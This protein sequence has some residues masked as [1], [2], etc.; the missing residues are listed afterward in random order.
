MTDETHRCKDYLFF[1]FFLISDFLCQLVMIAVSSELHTELHTLLDA[2][3]PDILVGTESWLTP[4][5]QNSEIIPP[6]LGYSMFREDR[7]SSVGG[8]VFIL[9]KDTIIASEMPQFKTDCEVLWIKLE[10]VGRK[11]LFIAAYYR[12]KEGDALST[13]EFQ[14]SIEMVSQQKGDIWILGDLNY[15]K[16]EWDEDDVPFIKPGCSH[17]K[18]YDSFIETMCDHSLSQMVREPTRSGNILDLFLTTYPTLVNSVSIIP[19]LSDHNIVKCIDDT[20]PKLTRK[21]PRKAHLYRKANWEDFRTHMQFFCDDFMYFEQLWCDFK[22]ALNGG[23][24]K[25][26]PSRLVGRKRH[27]PWIT[28]AI[29][30][31]IRK[32]DHLFQKFKRSKDPKDRSAFLKSRHSV[33]QKIKAA[34]NK[35]LE[36]IL[37]LKDQSGE[38]PSKSAFSRKKL[39]SFIKSS[40]TDTQGI[41]ILKK[42]ESNYTQSADQANVL[43]SQFQSVFSIRSPLDLYKLCHS[44]LLNGAASLTSLLPEDIQCKFPVMSDIEISVNGVAKLLS[45]LNSAKAAGPDA[46]RPIVLKELSHVIAPIVTAIFRKSLDTGK[47]P[48][49]WKKAQVCPLFKKGNKQDPANYRP[50]SLTCILCKTMEHIIASGLTKHLNQNNI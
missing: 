50:I 32:R 4:D 38:D 17:T 7:M 22:E 30:R 18:L 42:G 2:E 26:I 25:F 11:P 12:P 41:T 49:D 3:S 31:E 39:F 44:A 35:Y 28:Q 13:E 43:N 6:D 37:G 5:I 40:H 29:K 16:L 33:K 19:G 15:P 27:L 23:I 47:I 9:V 20:K 48:S 24:N 14:K 10:L 8:G 1:C 46:I 34:H 36:D 45:N 21:A